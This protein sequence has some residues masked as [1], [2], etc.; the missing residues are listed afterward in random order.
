[1][2]NEQSHQLWSPSPA[3][4]GNL[5]DF[6][7]LA[8]N[9]FGL[10][11]KSYHDLHA[12]SICTETSNDFWILL[13]EYLRIKSNRKP[14]IAFAA[15]MSTVPMF[16]PPHFF[17]EIKLN[18]T[19]NIFSNFIP[20]AVILH[21]CS[22]GANHVRDVTWDELRTQVEKIASAMINSG[23]SVGD[24]VAAIISNRQEAIASCLATLSLGAIWSA[25]SPEMGSSA[26]LSRLTQI[27]PKLIIC[28]SETVYNNKRRDLTS[29]NLIW[30]R[31]LAQNESLRS[32]IVLSQKKIKVG[33]E[34]K[35]ILWDRFLA[36]ATPR[37]LSF[38]QLPFNHPAFIVYSS[39]TSGSP[40]CI[41]H[42][43]G[44]LLIQAKKDAILHYDIKPRDT[45]MQY[46][47]TGWIMW[48]MVLVSLTYGG[49]VVLYDGSPF[50]P[51]ELVLLRLVSNLKVN[52]FGTSAKF[53]THLKTKMICP[54]KTLD[55]SHLRTVTSTGS[56]LT[57]DVATWFY[58]H[59]FPKHIHLHST[60][61]GTDLA[62]SLVTGVPTIPLFAGEIQ[63]PS[64]GMAVDILSMDETEPVSVAFK[65]EAG[66]LACLKPF[67]SQPVFF[68][69][70][71]E[72]VQYKSSYFE[73]FG[74]HTWIQGDFVSMNPTTKGF[75]VHGRSDGV[76]NPSGV[77]FGSA[78]IYNV[79]QEFPEVQDSLCVGQRRKDDD[80]EHVVLFV[81]LRSKENLSRTLHNKLKESIA[82]RLS[83]RHVPKF[84]FATPEI[85][86]TINGKKVE[87][88]VKKIISGQPFKVS[89]TVQ[90]PDC[91]MFY[92]SFLHVEQKYEELRKQ[93]K[94]ARL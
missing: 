42:S 39:G 63:G 80:D 54:K 41:V 58:K 22:E 53:L 78:E 52:V 71:K 81:Q 82:K 69:G 94:Y 13:F 5:K 7:N 10:N 66:E 34:F 70:D 50:I 14:S 24:R 27:R 30:A 35:M 15:K 3:N 46:T 57:A 44:G 20:S 43:A 56:P 17:P 31:K 88:L 68:W 83:K 61:G 93:W 23:V 51:D 2:A 55:L 25:S 73:K 45:V 6:I 89:P 59:G 12:W 64:L 75:T 65:G 37:K 91:L 47:T 72:N 40:K 1:M 11:L 60:C 49:K 67:P 62:C 90:N 84:I 9:R 36:L 32:I 29:T 85:P 33:T 77:R 19:E 16:P 87:I 38:V 28:E 21:V 48:V 76:L 79:V 92:Q 86:Y 74:A 26:I 18:F 4:G 8:N